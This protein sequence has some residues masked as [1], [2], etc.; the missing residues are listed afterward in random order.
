[1]RTTTRLA[2]SILLALA[3]LPIVAVQ[4]RV[5]E[6]D[7][8]FF[9]VARKAGAPL[10]TGVVT[11]VTGASLTPVASFTLDGVTP[12]FVLRVPID[13]LAPQDPGTA[14]PGDTARIYVDGA[15]AAT[16]TVG[17]RGTAT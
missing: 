14:R 4:A 2:T 5:P 9:G 10:T 1:M 6:P 12:N 16:S 3:L 11:V 8:I 17:E 13:S 15:L 7:H